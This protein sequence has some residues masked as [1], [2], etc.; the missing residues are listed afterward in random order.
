MPTVRSTR[1]P[2][3]ACPNGI[4]TR[5]LSGIAGGIVVVKE[6]N[7]AA[8]TGATSTLLVFCR[9]SGEPD[10]GLVTYTNGSGQPF[11]APLA[12][13]FQ[14]LEE[15]A[16]LLALATGDDWVVGLSGAHLVF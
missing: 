9:C 4:E 15:G 6:L 5:V 10:S 12:G 11:S 2:S 16:S 7:V 1:F 8:D 14:C 3:V 13:L